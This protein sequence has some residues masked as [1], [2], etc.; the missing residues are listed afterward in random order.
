[1]S[2]KHHVQLLSESVKA[3]ST[4]ETKG[5]RW[6]EARIGDLRVSEFIDLFKPELVEHPAGALADRLMKDPEWANTWHDN[7]AASLQDS[8]IGYKKSQRAASDVMQ[9]LFGVD[10]SKHALNLIKRREQREAGER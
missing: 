4:E 5:G 2:Q 10:T 3:L 8:G 9:S 1:M 6:R 7:I